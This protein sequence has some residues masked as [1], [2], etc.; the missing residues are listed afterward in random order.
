[1]RI[2]V[3][4]SHGTGKSTLITA[5]LERC[6]SYA[7][8]PEAFETLGDDVDFVADG[9]PSPEGL[10]ALL[11]HTLSAVASHA[12][13]ELVVFERSPVDYLAY[14]AAAR[15]SWP[16]GTGARFLVEFV[17]RV[18]DALRSLDL[19]AFLPVSRTGP[20][21]PPG[22]DQRFRERVDEA[23]R[24]ALLDDEHDLL[25]DSDAPLVAELA[26]HS[27]RRLPELVRLARATER[28]VGP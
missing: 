25:G 3:S 18:R 4:G 10:E 1:V 8:E 11:E 5:F 15:A 26:P 17:P 22:E 9:V 14:A 27:E 13:G 24:R 19:I 16:G 2:A 20:E 23:L 12:S 6:P 21:P 28:S 7:H